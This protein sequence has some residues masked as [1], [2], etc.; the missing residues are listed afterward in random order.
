MRSSKA[1]VSAT[2]R[3]CQRYAIGVQPKLNRA[4]SEDHHLRYDEDTKQREGSH[5][6]T[7]FNRFSS[8]HETTTLD[9][10]RLQIQSCTST[11]SA[12]GRR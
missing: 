9:P 3:S 11:A 10:R 7:R 2:S 1:K 4:S 5:L 8:N 12:G 6:F